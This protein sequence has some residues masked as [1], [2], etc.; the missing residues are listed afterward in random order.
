MRPA[1]LATGALLFALIPGVA[2]A[3]GAGTTPVV[4]R[5]ADVWNAS[6][7]TRVNGA[8]ELAA[9]RTV[10]G[11]VAVDRKSTRLNSSHT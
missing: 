5:A 7:T 6:A 2:D 9:G 3:Q 11:S 8:Y 10:D 4:R 1:L